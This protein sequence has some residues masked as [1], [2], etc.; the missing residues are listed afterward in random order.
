M[1]E[2]WV[3]SSEHPSTYLVE[4]LGYNIM[5]PKYIPN[6]Y[7][8]NQEFVIFRTCLG[9]GDIG[10]MSAMPRL[11]KEKY[12]NCKIY[13]PSSE[14]VLRVFKGFIARWRHWPFPQMNF[15]Q[16][17]KN[18]PYIDGETDFIP[19]MIYHDHYRI[20]NDNV[21]D[22]PLL[23]QILRY[24][25]FDDNESADYLPELYFSNEE[26]AQGD[27]FIREH[28]SNNSFCGVI[29]GNSESHKHCDYYK[30]NEYKLLNLVDGK[31]KDIDY[32]LYYGTDNFRRQL[33]SR[34]KKIID[35]KDYNLTIRL[36]LYIRTKAKFNMGYTSS[37]FVIMGRHSEIYCINLKEFGDSNT[38]ETLNY[39]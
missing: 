5:F 16:I 19:G 33:L 22:E 17:F 21:K 4:R 25:R 10:L 31:F 29:I 39:L 2:H 32:F 18:N 6:S 35:L 23:K 12:P 34:N 20:Y 13:I 36:Q 9:L 30:N 37:I 24:W 1:P 15:Y 27:N 14:L 7:L 26:K 3:M 8:D 38:I 28:F 11:L